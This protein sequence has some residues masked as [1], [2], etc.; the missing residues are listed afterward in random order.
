M[1]YK[2]NYY[3]KLVQDTLFFIIPKGASILYIG[4]NDAFHLYKLKPSKGVGVEV[5]K[6]KIIL[7]KNKYPLMSFFYVDD[8]SQYKPTSK[9]DYVVLSGALGK[10]KNIVGLLKNIQKACHPGTRIVIY[11]H[12]YLWQGI[13]NIAEKFNLKRVEGVQNW[14]SVDDVSDYLNGSGFEITRVIKR[15]IL[16]LKLGFIGPLINLISVIIPIFDFFKLDQ[17]L[18]A[19]PSITVCKQS[20]LTSLTICIT[21]RNEKGN[22]ESIVKKI[23]IITEKQEILFVEGHSVDGTREEIERVIKKYPNKNVRVIGQPGK[24]QGDAIKIGYKEA[25][26]DIIIL[27]E[28]DGTS[29]PED[30]KYFYEAASEGRY[31]FIEGTRFVY[32]LNKK[33]MPI[34]KQIGNIILAKWFSFVLGQRSTDVLSGIKVTLKRDYNLIYQRWGFL[35]FNDPF[36]DFELLYGSARLG[37]KIGEIPMRYYPR[38]YGNSHSKILKHGFYLIKMALKGYF[39]FRSS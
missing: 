17:Y 29:N 12:N 34:L 32:S 21:V 2:Y 6:E 19:R 22:I 30:L 24:G 9:F 13:L 7:A 20:S 11:Q 3:R 8:F 33:T 23:P 5:D 39:T 38:V 16:P 1:K 28:G 18:I 14:I 15:T 35:G 36:G 10:T 25:S 4:F 26:G 37:L 31:E 27:Y